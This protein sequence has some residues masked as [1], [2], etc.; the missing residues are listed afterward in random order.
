M[1]KSSI[2]YRE[3]FWFA[4][5]GGVAEVVLGVIGLRSYAS[6]CGPGWGGAS[7]LVVR[8]PMSLGS[9][10]RPG[11]A[12]TDDIVSGQPSSSAADRGSGRARGRL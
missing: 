5:H 12:V 4:G 9:G 1:T 8:P 6:G 2:R 11:W 10:G 3:R 7:G